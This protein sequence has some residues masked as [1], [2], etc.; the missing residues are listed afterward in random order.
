MDHQPLFELAATQHGLVT[1][2]QLLEAGRD[3]TWVCRRLDAGILLQI[4]SRVL[5]VAGIPQTPRQAAMASVL[6][7]GG[8]ATL[9]R[10]SALSAWGIPGFELAPAHV[11]RTRIGRVR[12]AD[13]SVH[14]SRRLLA[15]HVTAIH[16][17]PVTTMA[18]TLVD[19]AGELPFARLERIC[20]WAWARGLLTGLSLHRTVSELAGRGR[21][22]S[23][24]LRQLVADR[25]IGHRPP[26]SNLEA[27]VAQVLRDAGEPPLERQPDLGHDDGW[28]GRVDFVDRRWWIVFEVQSDLFHGSVSAGRDDD[29]RIAALRA[30]GFTVV[31]LREF[32]VWHRPH[33]IVAAVRAARAEAARRA[34]LAA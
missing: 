18:R 24:A 9:A 7:A 17:L 33:R 28:I 30:A 32:D 34:A 8:P 10:R 14:T 27:R 2:Q 13:A 23:A 6:D 26:E 22:G 15:H 31:E 12:P 11:V 25:P 29:A 4:S 5:R 19:V 3:W 1:R 20:D 16:G 21:K